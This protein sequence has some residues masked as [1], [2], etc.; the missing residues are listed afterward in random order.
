M[1]VQRAGMAGAD[2]RALP[3]AGGGRGATIVRDLADRQRLAAMLNGGVRLGDVHGHGGAR[4][5]GGGQGRVTC[6]PPQ[7][8]FRVVRQLVLVTH[9]TAVNSRSVATM[10]SGW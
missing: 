2:L 8:G 1:D 10:Y 5:G 9:A 7:E 3:G 4:P 6:R